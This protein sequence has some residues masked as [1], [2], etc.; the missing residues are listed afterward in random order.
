MRYVLCDEE[1]T[2]ELLGHKNFRAIAILDTETGRFA[3]MLPVVHASMEQPA[4][5]LSRLNAGETFEQ[6]DLWV[7]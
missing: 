1:K 2:A 7:L 4:A 5:K 3:P 6:V